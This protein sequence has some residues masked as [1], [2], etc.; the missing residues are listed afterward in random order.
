MATG[1]ITVQGSSI[2]L[3]SGQ[4]VFSA[5]ITTD[6]A[7]DHTLTT[8][9]SSGANTITVPSTATAALICPPSANTETI[10]LKGVTGD[11]GVG[12]SPSQA[13]LITFSDTPPASFVLTAGA[14][15]TGVV[16]AFL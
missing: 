11:T 4:K 3:P 9:L 14:G 15:I 10:V 1:T 5:T 7:I 2:D 16:I 12:I 13:T 6:A 8:D